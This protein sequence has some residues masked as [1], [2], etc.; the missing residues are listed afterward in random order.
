MRFHPNLSQRRGRTKS[1]FES[2]RREILS[3]RF[4]AGEK[5]P[6][7]RTL[8]R[9][10]GVARGTVNM[11]LAQLAAEGL[12]A[13]HPAAGVRVVFT[14]QPLKKIRHAYPIKLSEWAKRLPQ[15]QNKIAT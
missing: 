4:K 5:L 8:A 10:R 7:S 1:I 15:Q 14:T 13:I 2:L 11:A 6:G 9:S 12:V 3:G